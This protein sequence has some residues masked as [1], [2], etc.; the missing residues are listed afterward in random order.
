MY[1]TRTK[2]EGVW[3]PSVSFLGHRVSTDGNFAVETHLLDANIQRVKGFV[4]VAFIGFIRP[5][6]KFESLEALK[7][8]IA[9]D[10]EKAKAALS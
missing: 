4:E 1:A 5:N 6:Q 2:V 7:S 9:E 10:I 8:Q 3:Y